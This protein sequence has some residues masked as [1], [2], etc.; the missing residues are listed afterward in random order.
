MDRILLAVY[1]TLKEGYSNY[2]RYLYPKKPIFQGKKDLPFKMYVNKGIPSL[3]P[4]ETTNTIQI[5]V[6][7]ITPEIL[8]KIDK[9]E[10]VP[11]FYKRIQITLPEFEQEIFIYINTDE[12]PAGE[13]L[14]EGVF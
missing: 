11:Y 2:Y 3:V 5:E 12:D 6:F 1:G 13:K 9:L 10:G 7:E 4:S 14:K 8:K